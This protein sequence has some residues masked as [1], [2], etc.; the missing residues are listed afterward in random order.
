MENLFTRFKSA[1]KEEQLFTNKSRLLIAISGGVDSVVLADLAC[2]LGNPIILAHCNFNLRGEESLRDEKFV[3]QFA[4]SK[5][6]ELLINKFDTEKYAAS[7]SIS[8]QEAARELRYDWFQQL[9][10][11]SKADF[12][13]TA[14]HADDNIE[15]VAMNFFR[16]TGLQGLEG[17][18][19]INGSIRRPLLCF[20]KS[21]LAEYAREH[22]LSFVEDTSNEKDKYTRNHFRLNILPLLEKAYPSVKENLLNNIRRFKGVNKL[23]KQSVDQLLNKLIVKTGEEEKIPVAKLKEYKNT[24]LLYEW[25]SAF[26]FQEKQLE[27]IFNL[28]DAESG[29]YVNTTAHQIFKHRNWLVIS[30]LNKVESSV[31]IIDEKENQV[32]FSLGKLGLKLEE[33]VE[34]LSD[35][36]GAIVSVD[37]KK[38]SYP[39]ILRRHRPGDYF[40]PLGMTKKKKVA[41]FLIDI[42]CSKSEK[43]KIWV[44]ESNKK[45]VWVIGHRIDNRFK[46]ES[47]TKQT[48]TLILNS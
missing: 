41:R 2:K 46:I 39:L 7:K 28:L 29:K 6:L 10:S 27:Q 18:P 47:T 1:V 8:I 36:S 43:E 22:G 17:I 42:K 5:G 48:L 34:I 38:I 33:K 37:A 14:H 13:L 23:Y 3:Q 4:L 25:V 16:G 19:Q 35:K 11:E 26:G 21:E 9:I 40:Y 30:P 15:T 45:I 20:F 12:I 31:F 24:S 44:L 32:H